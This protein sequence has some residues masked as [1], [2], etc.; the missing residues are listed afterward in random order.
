MYSILNIINS[1]LLLTYFPNEKHLKDL[2]SQINKLLNKWASK[3]FNIA[4]K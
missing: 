3:T 1:D 4:P 2:L